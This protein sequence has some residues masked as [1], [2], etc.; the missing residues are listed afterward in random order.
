LTA[1]HAVCSMRRSLPYHTWHV[2]YCLK[3]RRPVDPM[4]C[5]QI[6]VS[7]EQC[8]AINSDWW[9]AVIKRDA[10]KIDIL[11]QWCLQ[12]L[13]AIKMLPPWPEWWEKMDNQATTPFGCCPSTTSLPV[14]PHCANARRNGWKKILTASFVKL[15]ETTRKPMYYMD[16]DLKSNNLSLNEA[17]DV[18]QNCPLWRLMSTFGAMHY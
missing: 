15:E 11:D 1:W 18:A 9:V 16:E 12:K 2:Y 3:L 7:S 6:Q 8:S 5:T 14:Q 4:Q 17:T 13:L 10:H